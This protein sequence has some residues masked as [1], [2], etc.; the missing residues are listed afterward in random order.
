MRQNNSF[1]ETT[2]SIKEKVDFLKQPDVYPEYVNEVKTKET[3]MSWVFLAGN[4]VYKLKKPIKYKFQ[5]LSTIELRYRNCL[6]EVRLNQALAKEIYL[7][8][9]PL[10]LGDDGK[11]YLEKEGKIV[12]WLIKMKRIPDEHMLDYLIKS[13]QVEEEQIIDAAK[14]LANFYKKSIPFEIFPDQYMKKLEQEI[15]DTYKELLNQHFDLPLIQIESIFKILLH[16][17]FK[18]FTLFDKRIFTRRIIEG[19]GDLRPE[20]IRIVPYPVI[21]DCLEFSKELRILDAAEE[22]SYLAMECEKLGNSRVG[23]L[24]FDTYVKESGDLIP[25]DLILFYK[26]KRAFLR[27]YLVAR[28]MAEPAYKDKSKWFSSANAYLNLAEKYCKEIEAT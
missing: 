24:F 12:D 28:H 23:Q 14:F 17:L 19:H 26:G 8:V 3:H 11:L 9:L 22:L 6:E 27:A 4:F 10:V 25:G 2:I 13:N 5:D 16:Y 20:H 1:S 7:K 21:I 18:H 15:I